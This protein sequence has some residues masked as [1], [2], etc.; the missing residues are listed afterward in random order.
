M[1]DAVY[2]G[3]KELEMSAPRCGGFGAPGKAW[4]I[5]EAERSLPLK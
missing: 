3:V 2:E 4:L 5:S 1:V